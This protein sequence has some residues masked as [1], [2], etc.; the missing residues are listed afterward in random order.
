MNASA[1][2]AKGQP[3]LEDLKPELFKV[4]DPV[5]TDTQAKKAQGLLLEKSGG[6]EA[7]IARGDLGF[8]VPPGVTPD[9]D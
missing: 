9:F 4:R 8:S 2:D 3:T 6:R 1:G 5:A 7:V